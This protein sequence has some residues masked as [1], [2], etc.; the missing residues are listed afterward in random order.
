MI[1]I[2]QKNQNL[3]FA[4]N[5]Q[6]VTENV[7]KK[8]TTLINGHFFWDTYYISSIPFNAT[9][10]HK[11]NPI[12]GHNMFFVGRSKI[13]LLT[14]NLCASFLWTL[15]SI[16]L[17]TDELSRI[18]ETLATIGKIK[19]RSMAENCDGYNNLCPKNETLEQ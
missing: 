4:H 2:K 7:W 12:E 16:V 13:F 9:S 14:L 8:G 5:L 11:K 3:N 18:T 1:R 6:G 17:C 15:G 10:V 19:R